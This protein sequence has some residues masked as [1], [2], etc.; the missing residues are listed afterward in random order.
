[1]KNGPLLH[2][3]LSGTE[4]SNAQMSDTEVSIAEVSQT[5]LSENCWKFC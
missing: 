2:H 3:W 4:L 5:D 1:M